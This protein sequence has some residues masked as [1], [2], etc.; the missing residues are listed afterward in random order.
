MHVRYEI[1]MFP[2][3]MSFL[4]KSAGAMD[5]VTWNAYIESSALHLR[6]LIDFFYKQ[7]GPEDDVLAEHYVI[8]AARWEEDRGPRTTFLTGEKARANK[9]VEHITFRRPR[10]DEEGWRWA[11]IR[12]Q[13]QP[14]MKS[15]LSHLP[16]ER[17]PWFTDTGL[18]EPS[19]PTGASSPPEIRGWTGP[20]E[21]T[22]TVAAPSPAGGAGVTGPAG[23]P[24]SGGGTEGG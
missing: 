2:A 1:V 8:D 12:A 24:D 9:R 14:V 3:T 19:G 4:S 23:P 10:T 11:E 20:P 6:N 18:E 16:A 13:L 7:Q 22:G 5:Q 15:F 21:P 17:R